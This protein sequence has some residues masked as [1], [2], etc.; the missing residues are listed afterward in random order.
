MGNIKLQE[1]IYIYIYMRALLRDLAHSTKEKKRKMREFVNETIN[2]FFFEES[3]RETKK[4][5]RREQER[6]RA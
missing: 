6:K 5:R 3:E 4:G 2:L 1:Q